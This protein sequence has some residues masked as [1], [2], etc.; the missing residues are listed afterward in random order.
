ME[1]GKIEVIRRS[2]DIADK[3]AE[4]LYKYNI[5]E[6][7]TDALYELLCEEFKLTNEEKN[8][9]FYDKS[10]GREINSFKAEMYSAVATLR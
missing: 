2:R 9:F 1:K 4:I 3:V 10:S 7:S 8:S 6:I 5:Q